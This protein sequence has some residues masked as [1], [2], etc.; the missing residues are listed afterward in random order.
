MREYRPYGSVEGVMSNHQ[1]LLRPRL[2]YDCAIRVA[3]GEWI[4]E[5]SLAV[6]D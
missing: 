2:E 6:N 5:N 3:R 4:S 1:F